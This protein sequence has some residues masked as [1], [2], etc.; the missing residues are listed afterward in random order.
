M[1]FNDN[2][3]LYNKKLKLKE[4]KENTRDEKFRLIDF[5]W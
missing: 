3:L 2:E 4:K 1:N 5:Y